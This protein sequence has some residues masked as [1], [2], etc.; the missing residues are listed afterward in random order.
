M[1]IVSV[2]GIP[3]K[4]E[5]KALYLGTDKVKALEVLDK[6][7]AD[8]ELEKVLYNRNL[9]LGAQTK[10]PARVAAEVAE[11]AERAKEEKKADA[12]KKK[13]AKKKETA[14]A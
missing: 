6:A 4:G 12:A 8:G 3:A 7:V 13:A 5:P 14:N 11:A 2:V 10:R 9:G 1:R